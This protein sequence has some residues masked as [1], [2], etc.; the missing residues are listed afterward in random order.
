MTAPNVTV[1]AEPKTGKSALACSLVNWPKEGDYPLILGFDTTGPEACAQLGYQIP[2]IRW[3][4]EPGATLK[5][6]ALS[7]LTKIEHMMRGNGKKP[8]AFVGDCGSTFAAELY[9]EAQRIIVTKNNMQ[10]YGYVLDI[11]NAFYRRLKD[12]GLPTAWLAWARPME[13]VQEKG[14][15]S[16]VIP[17]GTKVIGSFKDSLEGAC[18]QIVLLEKSA[19]MPGDVNANSDGAIRK[20]WTKDHAG[21]RCNGRFPVP[22]TIPANLAYLFHYIMQRGVQPVQRAG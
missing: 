20:F 5:E 16:H 10:R 14:G 6:K 13:V 8:C 21:Y 1:I 11:T 4:D 19:A 22:E 15:S 18:D 2:Y 9:D 12:F 17:G 7:M 3:K